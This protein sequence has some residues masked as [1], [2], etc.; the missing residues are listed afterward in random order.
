[1]GRAVRRGRAG[2]PHTPAEEKPSAFSQ[3][4][5]SGVSRPQIP[6]TLT[7]SASLGHRELP[8]WKGLLV[9]KPGEGRIEGKRERARVSPPKWINHNGMWLINHARD[10]RLAIL[11]F[12]LRHLDDI[13]PGVC[14]VDVPS[15][16]I[17]SDT[18]RHLQPGDLG[19][20]AGGGSGPEGQG[21]PP[22]CAPPTPFSS[23]SGG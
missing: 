23:R 9:R 13:P 15:D 10:Q 20:A 22:H 3:H 4:H 21:R 18:P 5:P 6:P 17:N 1:M 19:R 7:K 14:P 8:P 2:Q 12:H 16:P 11:A